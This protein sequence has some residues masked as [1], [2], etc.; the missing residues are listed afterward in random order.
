MLSNRAIAAWLIFL[1]ALGWVGW[2]HRHDPPPRP[3]AVTHAPVGAWNREQSGNAATIVAVGKQ[4]GVPRYGLQ[5]ALATAMQESNLHNDPGGPDDSA[6]LFQQRPSQGWGS[7]RQ[8]TD[9][10]YAAGKFFEHLVRVPNWARRALTDGAQAVQRSCC[11]G[12][13]AKWSGAADRLLAAL[14]T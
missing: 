8:V 1:V 11:P 7:Y 10:V 5:I 12:A 4:R 2:K 14:K 13:Y 6:G 9:P 3:A